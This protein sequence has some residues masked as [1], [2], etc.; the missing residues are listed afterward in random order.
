MTQQPRPVAAGRPTAPAVGVAA[1]ATAARLASARDAALAALTTARGQSRPATAVP[2]ATAPSFTTPAFTTPATPRPTAGPAPRPS[3]RRTSG[4]TAGIGVLRVI[5]WQLVLIAIALVIGR[6]WL[7]TGSVAIVAAIVVALTAVRVRGRWLFDWLALSTKYLLRNRNQD[8]GGDGE[9]GA[10][11]LRLVSP[12]AAGST[13]DVNDD[14]VFM[15]SRAP[16]ITAVLQPKS[17]VRDLTK[18]VQA[19][20]TLLPS[21]NGQAPTF[22]VQV[23]HH[24]GINRDRPPRMWVALQALRTV[25]AH[26]DEDVRQVLGNAVRRVQ[27]QLR[28]DGFPTRALAKHEVLGT[29]AALAHVNAGRGLVREEW[30]LW[31]SGSISQASFRLDGWADLATGV[32]TQLLRWLLTAAPQAAVTVAVTACRSPLETRPR[33]A[34]TVRVAAASPAAL[35]HA[36]SELTRLAGEWGVT[37]KRLDG[38]HADGLAATLP[39]GLADTA[40]R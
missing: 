36:E 29:L 12:E 24:A 8:L 22:A 2:A 33:V 40:A 13:E 7:T 4:R 20:E 17:T 16:G 23:V 32:A 11:L 28:R 18:M 9:T 1:P 10:A 6:P 34:A 35:A 38:Q 37:M 14:T 27:R 31:R 30:R 26:R 3:R 21:P 15:V 19:P 5:C 39:I 25:E